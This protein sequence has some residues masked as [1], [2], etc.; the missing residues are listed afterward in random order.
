MKF[1]GQAF[2]LHFP[3][4]FLNRLPFRCDVSLSSRLFPDI[5]CRHLPAPSDANLLVGIS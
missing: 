4:R 5:D 1:N 2:N 3:T